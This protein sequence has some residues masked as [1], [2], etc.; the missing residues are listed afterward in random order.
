[1]Q[2]TWPAGKGE[3]VNMAAIDVMRDEEANVYHVNNNVLVGGS[4][5]EG[6]PSW[7]R[8]RRGLLGSSCGSVVC[9]ISNDN[10]NVYVIPHYYV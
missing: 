7:P 6:C 5:V 1:M 8:V 10:D 3:R 4:Y 9:H 2:P